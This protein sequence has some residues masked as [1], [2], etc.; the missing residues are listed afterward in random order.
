MQKNTLH[1]WQRVY[2]NRSLNMASIKAIGFDMDHTLAVYHRAAFESLAFRETLKKFIEAGYPQELLDLEFD[3]NF[4]IRG[5]LVD[6]QRGNLLKV[7]GHKYVKVAFHG[8]KKLDKQERHRL[9]NQE[10]INV[11]D[12][13]SVDTFFALSE[14]QLYFEIVDYMRTNP[15]KLKKSFRE[16]YDDLRKFIDLSHADGS[17]KDSVIKNIDRYLDRDKARLKCLTRLLEGGKSVFL[18]TN[19]KWDYTDAVMSYIVGNDF[20]GYSNWRDLFTYVI[21]G[22][23]KPGFFSDS[24]PFYQVMEDSGLMKPH[25]GKLKSGQ[26]YQGGNGTL[27]QKL[28]KLKGDEILYC[29][30]HIFGDIIQ[31]KEGHNWRTL[32][33]VEE[34]TKQLKESSQHHSEWVSASELLTEREAEDEE[35][36]KLSSRIYFAKRNLELAADNKDQHK[37]TILTKKIAELSE[38]RLA[39]ESNVAGIDEQISK[40]LKARESRIHSIWGDPFRVGFEKSRFA[41]QIEEYACLYTTDIGNLRFYSPF[42]K[43]HSVHEQMP[44][45]IITD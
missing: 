39:Y 37:E 42:K 25:Y 12:L 28:T 21:V 31:S 19:S 7:D 16:V 6:T 29:G 17:I 20:E 26:I 41:A 43:F 35:V 10:S 23:G 30:D 11:A 1:S 5:L 2:V 9:Y 15:G 40:L 45:D 33:V 24:Q 22:A 18:L 36:Q 13:L 4:V 14:V 27:F 38:K 8:R 3:P 44:H 34:L 32:L